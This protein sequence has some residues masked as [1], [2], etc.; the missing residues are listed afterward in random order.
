MVENIPKLELVDGTMLLAPM[1]EK[2]SVSFFPNEQYVNDLES[3]GISTE[4]SKRELLE[5]FRLLELKKESKKVESFDFDKNKLE[6]IELILEQVPLLILIK[7]HLLTDEF[8]RKKNVR[9]CNPPQFMPINIQ[10]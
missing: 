7:F 3:K 4:M 6:P 8:V 2:W 10:I 9:L 5:C 1:R